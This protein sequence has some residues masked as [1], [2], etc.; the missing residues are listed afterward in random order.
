[1]RTLDEITSSLQSNLEW[2]RDRWWEQVCHDKTAAL[3]GHLLCGVR[4]VQLQTLEDELWSR[5]DEETYGD[6]IQL[7]LL[8]CGRPRSR[9]DAPDIWLAVEASAVLNHSDVEQARRRAAALRS[10]GFLAIPTVACEE[11]TPD[12]EEVARLGCVLLVQEGRR[13][14][15]EEALAEVVPLVTTQA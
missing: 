7:D 15:W 5:L 4:E 12:V 2:L 9:P 1:M 11:A 10:V 14:F 3:F 6:L 13:L 8:V